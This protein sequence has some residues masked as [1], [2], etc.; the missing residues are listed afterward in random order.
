M[1]GVSNFRVMYG[2]E[3][4]KLMKRKLVWIAGTI[5]IA[6]ALLMV[7]ADVTGRYYV[8]GVVYDTHYH[9]METDREYERALSGQAIDRE[10]IVKMQE[11]YRKIP[12]EEARYSLTE[13]YQTYARPYSAIFHIVRRTMGFSDREEICAWEADEEEFYDNFINSA[14]SACNNSFLSEREKAYWMDKIEALDKPLIFGYAGGYRK[15]ILYFQT[16]CFLILFF[17]VVCLSDLF[18]KE[19]TLKTD[20]LLLS[21]RFG[22]RQMYWAK[23]AAGMSFAG[24]SALGVGSIAVA[25]ALCIY[26]TDGFGVMIQ[27]AVSSYPLPLTMGY[28]IILMLCLMV[29]AALFTGVFVMMLSE[30][31]HNGVAV[32]ATAGGA[33]LMP[34]FIRIPP[35]YRLIA[36]LWSYLPGNLLDMDNIFSLRLIPLF[37]GYLTIW[38]AAPVLYILLGVLFLRRGLRAYQKYQVSGR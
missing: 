27:I 24:V 10:L 17:I 29:L 6:L 5:T 15:L 35:Q 25:A 28:T 18:T 1:R 22:K 30:L 11:A 36:Q 23:T 2:Y 8:D 13:E 9:M 3:I 20:Q 14:E 16:I 12:A 4:K 32:L 19:H 31:L 21:S 37:G 26:G 33:I 7:I 34:L 38:Q